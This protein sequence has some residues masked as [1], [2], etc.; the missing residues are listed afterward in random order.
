[1]QISGVK[2]KEPVVFRHENVFRRRFGGQDPAAAADYSFLMTHHPDIPVAGPAR[3]EKAGAPRGRFSI[4]PVRD[5]DAAALASKPAAR[6]TVLLVEDEPSVRSF[7][8]RALE[9]A[10]FA[11]I[12]APH[13]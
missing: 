1:M 11:V 5:R 8:Q 2:C 12:D 13:P 3:V 4:G 7:V 9:Q 10:G 6:A